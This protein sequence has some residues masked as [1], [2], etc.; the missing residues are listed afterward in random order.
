MFLEASKNRIVI[1][2]D[3]KAN[4]T[5]DMMS[6]LS[7]NE[8]HKAVSFH[9]RKVGSVFKEVYRP[10]YDV[11]L[12]FLKEIGECNL[13][14][15]YLKPETPEVILDQNE[16]LIFS[17]TFNI[18]NNE[19]FKTGGSF[20]YTKS[21][22]RF[23][24]TDSF[25]KP[26][27]KKCYVP[28]YRAEANIIINNTENIQEVVVDREIEEKMR[29]SDYFAKTVNSHFI[30]STSSRNKNSDYKSV[31]FYTKKYFQESLRLST[32][33]ELYQKLPKNPILTYIPEN[34]DFKVNKEKDK[35]LN[36]KKFSAISA[37]INFF[38]IN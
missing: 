26:L 14:K 1:F 25:I 3:E 23:N 30:E 24:K 6:P 37:V 9:L 33:P 19:N 36:V 17:K 29:N 35:N 22:E 8:I 15:S 21:L 16:G 4:E 11:W 5:I 32:K 7:I 2:P 13:G 34:F 27:K 31:T 20:N 18:K 12:M 38:Y 10:Y 28:P